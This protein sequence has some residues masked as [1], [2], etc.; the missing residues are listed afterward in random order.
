M[1]SPQSREIACMEVWGGNEAFTGSVSV[2]GHDVFISCDP[3]T[4][5]SH[6]GDVYYVSNCAAGLITRFILADI[7]GHG[8]EAAPVAR[9][10]RGLMRRHINTA[11]QSRF[12]RALNTEFADL[13][14]DGRFAT[15]L[16][17]TYFAPTDH[18]ILCNAGHPRP[19]HY[20]AERRRWG[21]LDAEAPGAVVLARDASSLGVNNLPL[22]ILAPTSYQQFGIKM[23]PG[24]LVV[25]YSDA[26]M[27]AAPPGGRPIGEL[28]LLRLA[29]RLD[30]GD[31]ASLR[32]GLLE[33]ALEVSGRDRLDDDATV[34][35]MHH[36]AVDP[37][38][39]TLR[40]RARALA[41][42]IGIG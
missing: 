29:A 33:A 9:R 16:L 35:V 38:R 14:A 5:T 11:D 18:L 15:A 40:A 37:P 39:A 2:P 6:G 3:H 20:D 10:L 26:L 34:I 7:S 19:L 22:G 25:I 21:L 42:L 27:E 24:D 8:P 1:T 31:P 12:A 4:G 30:P 23:N 41:H 17:L 36:N 13:A 32:A 28:G